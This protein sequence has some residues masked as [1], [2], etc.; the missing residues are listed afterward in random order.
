MPRH[1]GKPPRNVFINE[2]NYRI[3]KSADYIGVTQTK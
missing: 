1:S 3:V 2:A